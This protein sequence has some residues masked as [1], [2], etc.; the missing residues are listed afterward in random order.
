MGNRAITCDLC[1][2]AALSKDDV[3]H[4]PLYIHGSEGADCCLACRLVLTEVARALARARHR[5]YRQAKLRSI[6]AISAASLRPPAAEPR[7]PDRPGKV[8][9]SCDETRIGPWIE[10]QPP[11]AQY[12]GGVPGSRLGERP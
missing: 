11:P 3:M 7:A 8:Y 4:L 10:P 6:A 12:P 2:E 9:Q 5:G 1:G